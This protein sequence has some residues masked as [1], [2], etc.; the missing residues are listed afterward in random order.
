MPFQSSQIRI[1]I[2]TGKNH[3]CI[4]GVICFTQPQ[5][6]WVCKIRKFH[7]LTIIPSRENLLRTMNDQV[8]VLTVNIESRFPLKYLHKLFVRLLKYY[9]DKNVQVQYFR[10]LQILYKFILS[11]KKNKILFMI[12]ILTIFQYINCFC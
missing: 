9:S 5:N 10:Y 1:K 2:V 6:I 12:S 3:E 11:A 7:S 8:Y 4:Y